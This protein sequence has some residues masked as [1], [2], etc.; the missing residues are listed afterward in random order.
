MAALGYTGLWIISVI[1]GAIVGLVIGWILWS[2]GFRMIGFSVALVGAGV[3]GIIA[4]LAFLNWGDRIA[5]RR[6]GSPR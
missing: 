6:A 3:G 2:L 1:I 5:G 4:F